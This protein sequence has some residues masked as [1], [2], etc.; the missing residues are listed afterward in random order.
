M[1]NFKP[2]MQY[3]VSDGD[4]SQNEGHCACKFPVM[5]RGCRC[6][7]TTVAKLT[8]SSHCRW[9]QQLKSVHWN[10]CESLTSDFQTHTPPHHPRSYFDWSCARFTSSTVFCRSI[11]YFT[12]PQ[13]SCIRVL[14]WHLLCFYL[15]MDRLF[16][17][18]FSVEEFT[19]KTNKL[20]HDTRASPSLLRQECE[21]FS[22]WLN[23]APCF[24]TCAAS[25]NFFWAAFRFR[26]GSN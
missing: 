4:F 11:F 17:L 18:V 9:M 7:H 19:R 16:F 6:S 1:Q 2:C 22:V 3:V 25:K 20:M 10:Q 26:R 24:S 15:F 5:Q 8:A 12:E 21:K 13:F 14:H 23:A